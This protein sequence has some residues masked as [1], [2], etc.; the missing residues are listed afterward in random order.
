MHSEFSLHQLF[1]DFSD[2]NVIYDLH[3][4]PGQLLKMKYS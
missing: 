3:A 4:I 1:E 2:K